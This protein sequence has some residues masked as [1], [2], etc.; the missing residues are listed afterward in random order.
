[1]A[2]QAFY[3]NCENSYSERIEE[4]ILEFSKAD[5]VLSVKT[6][7]STGTPKQIAH[8]K[9][10]VEVS[11]KRTNSYF[12]LS[13]NSKVL[14]PI[15]F[16]TI[17]GKMALFRA[18]VG[19]YEIHFATPSRVFLNHVNTN[20]RFDLVS[21]APLQLDYLIENE[22]NRIDQFKQ[23]LL[24]GSSISSK[25][26]VSCSRLDSK[27]VLGFGMTETISH[28]AIREMNTAVYQTL[29]GISIESTADGMEIHD[30]LNNVII[31]STDVIE[32]IDNKHFKWLGRNDF[33]INSGGVKIH[34]EPIEQRILSQFGIHSLLI[35]KIDNEFG[36][37]VTLIVENQIDDDL[38]IEITHLIQKEFGKYAVPKQYFQHSFS[39]LNGL[40]LDRKKIKTQIDQL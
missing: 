12:N 9:E 23:I 22:F 40:K 15:S 29:N 35:G 33:V 3:H 26:E 2:F 20:I 19:N 7:G 32:K 39:Y 10:A 13:E 25:L 28:I 8:Q 4:S 37:K 27:V 24:G 17:G 11:A 31:H 14:C 34:P 18:I 21:M 38:F 16:D 5:F 30:Q 36:E 1:M 6:S